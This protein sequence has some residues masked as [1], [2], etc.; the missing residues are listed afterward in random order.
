MGISTLFNLITILYIFRSVQLSLAIWREW[1]DIRVEPLTQ[2]KKYLAEQASFYIAVPVGVFF[3]ELGHALAVKL[4]G[5]E[6]ISFLSSYRFFWGEVVHRGVY[7]PAERWLISLA[8]TLGSLL[9]G[10]GI[11]LAL[12]H[13]PVSSLRYFGLRAF[14]FQ[15]YFSLL[16]YPL[17]S[18][19][20]PIGDWRVIY[21][22]SATPVLS[23][24]MLVVHVAF[25]LFYWRYDRQG[26]FE[27]PA[28]ETEVEQ[29]QF[30]VLAQ[31]AQQ[32][33]QDTRLQLQYVDTLRRGGAQNRAKTQLKKLLAAHPNSAE[34]YLELAA[35]E[36]DSGPQIS[37]KASG[38]AAIALQNGL[39]DPVQ[40]ALAKRMV[41]QYQLEVGQEGEA[42]QGYA[43]ALEAL[44]RAEPSAYQL[45]LLATVYR[46][47]GLAYRRLQKYELA[48]ADISQA[49]TLAEQGGFGEL[50]AVYQNDLQ[51]LGSHAGHMSGKSS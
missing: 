29:A 42:L 5:G 18:I 26:A 43:A 35:V 15:I 51:V 22:F 36:A 31:A 49:L 44:N 33:P 8:G 17:F 37:K 12:R 46:E 13:N 25:L 21:D 11:W 1:G 3:H 27:A 14:R 40:E 41:A 38:Y 32:S 47:R 24:L 6:I 23:G 45:R 9:F 50:T 4:Y 19:F 28:L 2:R 39:A 48:Y 7:T 20:L 30:D 34:A 10:L 16:Y